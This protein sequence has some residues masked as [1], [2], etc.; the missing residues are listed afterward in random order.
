MKTT[1]PN[2]FYF[3]VCSLVGIILWLSLFG[4]ASGEIHQYIQYI[5]HITR[6]TLFV[7]KKDKALK[8]CFRDSLKEKW[9]V[10]QTK[11]F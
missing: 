1:Q 9:K 8:N 11:N 6:Y 3:Y 2:Y 4:I 7:W 5:L 10:D